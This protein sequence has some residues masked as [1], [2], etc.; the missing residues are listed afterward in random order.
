MGGWWVSGPGYLVSDLILEARSLVNDD[1]DETPGWIP[2]ERW[3]RWLNWEMQALARRQVEMGMVRVPITSTTI[4]GPSGSIAGAMKVVNV[5]GPDDEELH[6]AQGGDIPEPFWDDTQGSGVSWAAHG[7]GDTWTV[8]ISPQDTRAY[9]VR[10]V[11]QPEYVAAEDE[12]ILLPQG[13]EKRIVYGMASH[14]L[15]KESAASAALERKIF[16]AD[17]D[18]GLSLFGVGVSP[19]VRD[20]RRRRGL[21]HPVRFTG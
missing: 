3:I 12:Y 16:Q 1:H 7:A 14:A 4:T 5:I 6:P 15:L 13:F 19:R 10:F 17:A 20:A 8:E 18:I 11:P 21:I 9:T 2:P